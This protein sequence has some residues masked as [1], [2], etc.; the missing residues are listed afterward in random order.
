M[1]DPIADRLAEIRCRRAGLTH[2]GKWLAVQTGIS[3]AR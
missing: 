2:D 1:N 3:A